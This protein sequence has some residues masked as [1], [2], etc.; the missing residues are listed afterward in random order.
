MMPA[1]HSPSLMLLIPWKVCCNKWELENSQANLWRM[2]LRPIYREGT[3]AATKTNRLSWMSAINQAFSILCGQF[4][5]SIGIP[6]LLYFLQYSMISCIWSFLKYLC[7]IFLYFL[8]FPIFHI[9]FN[10]YFKEMNMSNL[11]KC[12]E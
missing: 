11:M 10:I 5:L 8:Y 4:R 3:Q 7:E 1:W 12:A 6:L 9:Y 2:L